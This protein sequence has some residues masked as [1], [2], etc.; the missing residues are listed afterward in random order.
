MQHAPSPQETSELVLS[1]SIDYLLM[2]YIVS[3]P[4]LK[5]IRYKMLLLAPKQSINKLTYETVGTVPISKHIDR[6]QCLEIKELKL[7]S[8]LLFTDLAWTVA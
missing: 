6:N 1:E 4:A 8:K 7:V 2:G 3:L 5:S